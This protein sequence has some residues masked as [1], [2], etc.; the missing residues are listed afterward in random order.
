WPRGLHR[1]RADALDPLPARER[2]HL[3][4]APP[5]RPTPRTSSPP[6]PEPPAPD[7]LPVVRVN[8]AL[9]T[10]RAVRYHHRQVGLRDPT[11]GQVFTAPALQIRGPLLVPGEFRQEPGHGRAG[12]VPPRHLVPQAVEPEALAADGRRPPLHDPAL[13]GAG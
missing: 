11:G 5:S 3:R 12:A 4:L 1:R 13:E 6:P 2:G 9:R 7:T 8:P 10:A